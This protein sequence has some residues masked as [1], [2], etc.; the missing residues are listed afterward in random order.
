MNDE[1]TFATLLNTNSADNE[2]AALKQIELFYRGKLHVLTRDELPFYI[3]R[4]FSVNHLAVE[5]DTISRKHCILQMRDQQIGLLDIST[6]GTFVKPGRADSVFIRQEYY[7][8]VGQGAIKLGHKIDLED[9][10]LILFK[11]VNL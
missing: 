9:P 3:G 8:L 5:G 11:V 1:N 2:V 7:P 10:E 4:D 6:N